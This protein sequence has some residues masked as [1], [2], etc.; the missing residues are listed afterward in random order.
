VA[1]FKLVEP[2]FNLSEDKSLLN[3]ADYFRLGIPKILTKL[4]AVSL[5]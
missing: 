3:F 1:I 5:L 4:D 2:L